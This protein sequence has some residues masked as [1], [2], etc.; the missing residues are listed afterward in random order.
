MLVIC[1]R[2][3]SVA[4]CSHGGEEGA[5]L[6]TLVCFLVTLPSHLLPPPAALSAPLAPNTLRLLKYRSHLPQ[7]PVLQRR[8]AQGRH[9]R[10]PRAH[11]PETH[12]RHSHEHRYRAAAGYQESRIGYAVPDGGEHYEAGESEL[13]AL[14]VDG[15][16]GRASGGEAREFRRMTGP[17]HRA[18]DAC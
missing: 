8:L 7:G 10:P 12:S 13:E 18:R 1:R 4:V 17:V 3:E 6:A 11:G 2:C 14:E 5:D 15:R 9:H 16:G